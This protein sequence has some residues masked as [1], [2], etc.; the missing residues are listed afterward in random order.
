MGFQK[1]TPQNSGIVAGHIKA[2]HD[3]CQ[4]YNTFLFVRPSEQATMRLIAEGFA[5]KSMDIHDKSSNWGLTSG[6]VPIDQAFSKNLVG[7]P[8]TG[9]VPTGHGQALPVHLTYSK[10]QFDRLFRSNHFEHTEAPL[11]G[12]RC[13]QPNEGPY[14][15]KPDPAFVHIHSSK[16]TDVCLLWERKT[17]KV[18]WRNRNLP[19]NPMVPM[20]VWGYRVGGKISPVTGDYDL[21]MVAP[22]IT[23]TRKHR[24]ID[25]VKDSHGRSAASEFTIMLS[26]KLNAACG[27]SDNTVFNH[28]AEAQNYSFT[29]KIDRYLAAFA[30]GTEAPFLVPRMVMPGVLHDCLRHGYVVTRNPKWKN[31][32]TLGIEDM[33]AALDQFPKTQDHAVLAGKKARDNLE[34]SAATVL[35]RA[36]R[37]KKGYEQKSTDPGGV[38]AFKERRE[39]LRPMRAIGNQPKDQGRDLL[40][41]LSAFPQS[42]KY[43]D[44]KETQ[45]AI[46][47]VLEQETSFGRKGFANDGGHL[48][49]V[50]RT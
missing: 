3:V 15:A 34:S 28:G 18:F 45:E 1:L 14:T 37:A 38:K 46:S 49:P 25:S 27:R 19:K 48:V 30:P 22:H 26:G 21:W 8:K 39:E 32:S 20:W 29:Q 24:G 43:P 36:F 2:I 23:V 40:L 17:G 12:S 4:H 44:K 47:L 31:G 10:P 50:D 6:F 7:A 35:Q 11:P 41:P 16:R 9:I 5:T 13:V 33:A 42:T